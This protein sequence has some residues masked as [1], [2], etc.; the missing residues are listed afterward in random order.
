[1]TVGRR[2]MSDV[3]RSHIM[4]HKLCYLFSQHVSHKR[5]RDTVFQNIDES[6]ESS[7]ENWES[8]LENKKS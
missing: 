7:P 6:L 2:Q 8:D 4:N 5:K 3:G 1:M